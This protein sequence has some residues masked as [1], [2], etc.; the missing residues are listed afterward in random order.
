MAEDAGERAD[1]EVVPIAAANPI[2]AML[3]KFLKRAE[4]GE[5]S[6]CAVAATLPAA[7]GR[8]EAIATGWAHDST[9]VHAA[10][11]IGAT[12]LLR[13]RMLN[14]FDDGK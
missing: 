10:T 4:A 13:H 9:K 5:L 2:V 1:A 12:D 7:Q 14:G 11:L 3:R 6:S 8:E